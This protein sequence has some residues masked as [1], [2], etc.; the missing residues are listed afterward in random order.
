M[1]LMWQW[2]EKTVADFGFRISDFGFS[3]HPRS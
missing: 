1:A 3:A 2:L